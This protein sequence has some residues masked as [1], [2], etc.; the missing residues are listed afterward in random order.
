MG[1][2]NTKIFYLIFLYKKIQEFLVFFKLVLY[3]CL[4]LEAAL[5]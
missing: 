4:M 2:N 5:V 1:I 3:C